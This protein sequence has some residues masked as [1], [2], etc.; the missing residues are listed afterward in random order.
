M[1]AVRLQWL[2][3]AGLCLGAGCST[4]VCAFEPVDGEIA[5]EA[6]AVEVVEDGVAEGVPQLV[7]AKTDRF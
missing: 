6:V 2:G 7:V 4:D 5:R 3:I 1:R